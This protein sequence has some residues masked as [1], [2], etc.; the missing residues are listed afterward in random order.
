MRNLFNNIWL[1]L[2]Q[3]TYFDEDM[4][5]VAVPLKETEAV[6]VSSYVVPF[7]ENL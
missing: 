2:W 7:S 3:E 4:K 1:I 5:R 6:K